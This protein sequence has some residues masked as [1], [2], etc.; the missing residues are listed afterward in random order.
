MVETKSLEK[1]E[2]EALFREKDIPYK[3]DICEAI[4]LK[5]GEEVLG[6]CLFSVENGKITISY[7][8]PK[9]DIS[10]LDGVLR[11]A[12]FIAANRGI[13][14]AD[15]SE[16]VSGELIKRLGFCGN[17]QKRTIDITNLFSSCQNC[18]K[19]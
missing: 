9:D 12:L 7:L 11:S 5:S 19:G 6:S 16:K 2:T 17:E 10:L 1:K 13:M 18:R 4:V 15:Y 3:E 8:E 14:E